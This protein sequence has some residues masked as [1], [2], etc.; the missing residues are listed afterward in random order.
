MSEKIKNNFFEIIDAHKQL[1][2]T[3]KDEIPKHFLADDFYDD[4]IEQLRINWYEG[5]LLLF[6]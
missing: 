1:I 6:K 4:T 3:N 2:K 5:D